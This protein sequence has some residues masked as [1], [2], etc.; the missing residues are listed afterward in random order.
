L[1]S[2]QK[3]GKSFITLDGDAKPLAPTI[4]APDASAIA[5]V[6]EKA[7][8][9]VFGMDEMKVLSNGGRG[10]TLMELEPKEKLVAACAITQKGVTVLGTGNAGKA[11]EE[12]MTPHALAEG[13]HFG[14][15]ARKGKPMPTRIKPTGLMPN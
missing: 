14:K 5:V 10:V 6:S 11:K 15:R 8:L 2:R 4:V 12:R 9:L 7:R 1:V 13:E 3:S